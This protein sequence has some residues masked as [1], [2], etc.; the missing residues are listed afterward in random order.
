MDIEIRDF[1]WTIAVSE[2]RS[3]RQ[4][5][6]ALGVRQSILSRR[7]KTLETRL[8]VV[9][10]ERDRSGTRPTPEGLE[11]LAVARRVRDDTETLARKLK[12]KSVRHRLSLTIGM[13]ASPST[14]H[15]PIL[16]AEFMRRFPTI[17]LRVVDGDSSHLLE[18]VRGGNLD[19]AIVTGASAPWPDRWLGLW[20]ERIVAALPA[21]HPLAMRSTIGWRDLVST[22]ILLPEEGPGPELHQRLC[23]R[24]SLYPLPSVIYHAAALDRILTLVRSGFG[25]L[26]MLEGATGVH[27]DGVVYREIRDDGRCERLD[28]FACWS[29]SNRKTALKSFLETLRSQF[30]DLSPQE[31][32]VS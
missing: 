23:D 5:A 32:A 27:C 25:V 22:P 9:L 30:P 7:I 14:G 20:S 1:K 2:H 10:F 19:I 29:P 24:L 11:F 12:S 17:D 28:F 6:I 13:Q 15:M 4:A 16:L 18:R 21:E 3:M 26:L 31:S 8:G